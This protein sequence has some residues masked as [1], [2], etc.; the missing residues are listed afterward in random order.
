MDSGQYINRINNLE[1]AVIGDCIV[2]SRSHDW[3]AGVV[4]IREGQL[5]CL[6]RIEFELTFDRAEVRDYGYKERMAYTYRVEGKRK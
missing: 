1:Y 3:I 6:E 4:Y 5:Y 2:K